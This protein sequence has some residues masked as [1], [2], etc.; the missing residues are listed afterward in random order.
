MK[1]DEFFMKKKLLAVLTAA[2]ILT[3]LFSNIAFADYYPANTMLRYGSTGPNVQ[4]LQQDLKDL[5][6]FN[7]YTT[8]QYF[9][10]ITQN[11]V[12]AYQRAKGLSPDGIVGPITS[13]SLKVDEV[14]RIAKTYEGVPYVWGGSTPNGFDCSGLTSYVMAQNG[15]IIPRTSAQQYTVGTWVNKSA[16]QPGDLVF[17]ATGTPGV[18]SHVGIFIGNGQFIAASSGSGKVIVSQLNNPYFTQH[19]FGAKRVI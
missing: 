2:F 6:Y 19:Y 14:I 13:R 11:A 16:L 15:I 12:I 5:G 1:G 4:M 9:G 18:V 17:F 8:T 7:F 10:S 3:T